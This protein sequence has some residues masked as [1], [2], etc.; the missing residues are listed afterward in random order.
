MHLGFYV[1]RISLFARNME[2]FRTSN[3]VGPAGY[4]AA[5]LFSGLTSN[6]CCLTA[7]TRLSSRLEKRVK[8]TKTNPVRCARELR[9]A[10]YFPN[11][12][13]FFKVRPG[14][15]PFYENEFSLT[16]ASKAYFDSYKVRKKVL[17][18]SLWKRKKNKWRVKTTQKWP[19]RSR[20]QTIF[21]CEFWR[22][23][24]KNNKN[25]ALYKLQYTTIIVIL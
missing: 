25:K 8:K 24:N 16:Y 23:F 19:I 13:L 14:I 21:N 17:Q 5:L 4:H 18:N 6:F 7:R 15:Q 2:D 20:K 11:H 9:G 12:C 10:S 22:D 3:F 1:G